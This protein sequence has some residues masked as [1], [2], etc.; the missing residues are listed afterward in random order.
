MTAFDACPICSSSR[1]KLR[2]NGFTNRDPADGR[3]WSVFECEEC[4][5]GFIN[6]QPDAATLREYYPEITKPMTNAMPLTRGNDLIV[7]KRECG[8]FRHIPV[9]TGKRS[10]ISAAVGFLPGHLPKAGG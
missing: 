9:P 8:K 10:S 7:A 1:I 5:H 2:F 6:P 4:G 3:A